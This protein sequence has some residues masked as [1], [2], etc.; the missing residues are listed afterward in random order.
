MSDEVW[1]GE[2]TSTLKSIQK[3]VG[4]CAKNMDALRTSNTQEHG[5]MVSEV[6]NLKTKMAVLKSEHIS[7]SDNDDRRFNRQWAAISGIILLILGSA[8]F[9][10][11]SNL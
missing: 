3:E 11:R 4:Q 1:R 5:L 9:V 7:H 8:F 2:V 6:G 10:I